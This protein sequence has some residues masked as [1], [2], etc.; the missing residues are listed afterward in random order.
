MPL[1]LSK[2]DAQGMGSAITYARRY[3]LCAVLNLVA[4][5]DDDGAR[6]SRRA[7]TGNLATDAQKKRLRTDITRSNLNAAAMDGLFKRVEFERT[8][9][10][11][12]NDAINR[13]TA[14]QASGLIDT[15]SQG[16]IKTGG[17]T[18]PRARTSSSTRPP[19]LTRCSPDAALRL[20]PGA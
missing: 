10:E 16:A 15:I 9:G 6:A 18:S 11:K 12:V 20:R 5:D 7:S 14:S 3:A 1:L 17:R 13:L 19:A 2:N 4:D 8:E